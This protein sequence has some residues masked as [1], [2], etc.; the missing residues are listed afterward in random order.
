M[1]KNFKRSK[2]KEA[3]VWEGKSYKYEWLLEEVDRWKDELNVVQDRT[4]LCGDHKGRLFPALY[5]LVSRMQTKK[6]SSVCMTDDGDGDN[7][8]TRDVENY[9]AS[10]HEQHLI[11]SLCN[12][13]VAQLIS[14]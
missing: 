2:D 11:C 13:F 4:G 10:R 3:I 6:E 5:C 9:P 8:E 14:A 1:A 12:F 7:E